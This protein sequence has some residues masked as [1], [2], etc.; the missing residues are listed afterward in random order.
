MAQGQEGLFESDNRMFPEFESKGDY[1]RNKQSKMKKTQL[2]RKDNEL[3]Y[4]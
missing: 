3:I 4:I 2:Q 1:R